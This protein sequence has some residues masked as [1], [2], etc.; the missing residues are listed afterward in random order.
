[1]AA[2]KACPGILA[3]AHVT[4]GG[5]PD[6]LPRVLPEHLAVDLDL[7]ALAP[8]PVFGWLAEAGGV[9]ASEMLRTFNCGVGMVVY[10]VAGERSR[11]DDGA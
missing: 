5:F 6:N 1:M 8:P 2:L 4:G 7:A 10:A 3:L 11:S 9:A